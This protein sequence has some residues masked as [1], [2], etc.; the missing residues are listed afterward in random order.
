[1]NDA[2]RV[3]ESALDWLRDH[4]DH[5][6]F[7]KEDDV[8]TV[9]WGRMV[10]IARTENLPLVL[11]YEQN[12]PVSFGRLQCDIVVFG[13]G[14]KLLLCVEM[15][16]EPAR[17][18]P[19]IANRALKHSRPEHLLPGHGL[20]GF[21]CDIERIPYYVQEAGAEVAYAVVV[22]ENRYHSSRMTEK[23]IPVGTSW[24]KWGAKT[25]DGLNTAIMVSRFPF[26]VTASSAGA[27]AE[28]S[29]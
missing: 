16:Y 7:R 29:A 5:Y 18:R 19:D 12:F 25:P 15:K 3:F 9:L 2:V 6:L 1:M 23:Q 20:K 22:D 24:I 17:S 8:V 14:R 13:P 28:V 27:A 4:Y 26:E 21:R 10:S 11:D